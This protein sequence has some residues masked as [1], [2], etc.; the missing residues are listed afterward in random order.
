MKNTR[1]PKMLKAFN[2]YMDKNPDMRFFQGLTNFLGASYLGWA[3]SPEGEDFR[4][5]WN[6]EEKDINYIGRKNE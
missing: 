3:S 5:L 2:K 6:S 1:C 4:D